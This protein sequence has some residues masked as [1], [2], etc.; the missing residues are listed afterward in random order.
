MGAQLYMFSHA[1]NAT[2]RTTRVAEAKKALE[3]GPCPDAYSL[4]AT[5]E[6]TTLEEALKYAKQGYEAGEKAL[7]DYEPNIFTAKK[8]N[9][10]DYHETRPYIRALQ[11]YAQCLIDNG[12]AGDAVPILQ[13]GLELNPGDNIG[14]EQN[15]MLAYMHLK[16]FDEVLAIIV[17]QERK[18]N[19]LLFASYNY[20]KALLSYKKHGRT[21]QTYWALALAFKS[22]FN[23][24]DAVLEPEKF[25]ARPMNPYMN[26]QGPVEAIS[27]IHT[28]ARFWFEDKEAWAWFK[29]SIIVGLS[30]H[31]CKHCAQNIWKSDDLLS[32][33]DKLIAK[34]K[35]TEAAM[36]IQQIMNIIPGKHPLGMAAMTRLAY[37]FSN[38]TASKA[39]FN[40][41][42]EICLNVISFDMVKFHRDI[43]SSHESDDE[44]FM[45]GVDRE[46]RR[47][48]LILNTC[49]EVCKQIMNKAPKI[50]Y[51]RLLDFSTVCVLPEEDDPMKVTSDAKQEVE[52]TPEK[53]KELNKLMTEGK[54]GVDRPFSMADLTKM[55]AKST[56]KS[57]PSR[58]VCA[59]C[60]KTDIPLKQCGQC[61][62]VKYCSRECQKSDWSR[63]KKVCAQLANEL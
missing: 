18:H 16:K 49:R 22:N 45:L 21:E 47:L 23:V 35:F 43:S 4:L 29:R 36:L 5:E 55:M 27:F 38:G 7:I 58:N 17:K 39:S 59:K 8:G 1:F 6:A 52:L 37:C 24:I 11:T 34:T 63:H 54:P 13:K 30:L 28:W 44:Y 50:E 25:Y 14:L 42:K 33:V 9:F 31:P 2:K 20:T 51:D 40:R 19:V 62:Q 12:R 46:A 32:E 61:K 53:L 57:D 3:L 56:M 60:G 10:W 48:E 26:T 15:L 41:A